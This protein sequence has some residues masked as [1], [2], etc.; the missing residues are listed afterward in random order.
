MR[1]WTLLFSLMWVTATLWGQTAAALLAQAKTEVDPHVQIKLLTRAVEKAPRMANAYHYR[2]DAY[3][4]LSDFKHALEDY[5]KTIDLRPKDPF[6]YYA[7]A[8]A[9][10]EQ[11]RPSL[12]LADLNDA[13]R[14]K[15]TYKNFYLARARVYAQL[16]KH[17]KAVADYEKYR[18]G[19][20]QTLPV[21]EML[22]S[23]VGAYRYDKALE[24]L[25]I[26]PQPDAAEVHYWRGR[27]AWGRNE[28]D[29]AVSSFSK[30]INRDDAYAPAYR[31]RANAYKEMGD[32][33]AALEDYTALVALQPD[34]IFY[35]RR[36]LVQE[37][38]GDWAA[39]QDDYTQA[40]ELNPKWSIPYN[41]RGFVR[42][43]LKDWA[44]ATKDLET[45]ISLE[46]AAPTP[47]IN[48]A[49]VYWLSKKDR[50]QAYAYLD[51]ALRRNF[52]DVESLYKEDQKGWMFKGLNQTAQFRALLYK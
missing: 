44:G 17:D 14:L 11:K 38:L 27:V 50:K 19:T 22:P 20:T 23:Y 48:L 5:S 47:Y 6:R 1:K 2:A 49:G 52:R 36:G 8:L 32:L 9:Y 35:N 43:R 30:A 42:I 10:M 13:I 34:A 37:E 24:L 28:L 7:C 18:R 15:P 12:A 45:A 51:Q 29:E 46:P 31:Y 4:K 26:A 16:D 21:L 41:N 40:I 25:E 3:L 39:A 33:P